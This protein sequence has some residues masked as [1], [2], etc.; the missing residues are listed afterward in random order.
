MIGSKNRSKGRRNTRT[1]TKSIPTTT[2]YVKNMVCPK[3]IRVVRE[4]LRQ[5]HLD[6]RNVQ[7]GEVT[8]S[9][10]LTEVQKKSVKMAF[11]ANGFMIIEDKRAK[12]IE[13][14]KIAVLKLVQ[15]DY[16]ASPIRVK[17]SEFIATELGLNYYYLTTLFSSVE[18]ITI[19]HYAILQ[20]IERAKELIKYDE[21]TLSEISHKLGYSSLQ[22]L[23][24]QFKA[25]TGMS[26]SSF[27][28]LGGSHRHHIHQHH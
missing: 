15:N 1:P 9:G 24:N 21:L 17:Y 20:R 16:E 14:I 10:M 28:S 3:C 13:G 4:E 8:V 23:S 25:V 19:E 6:A 18:N 12:V 22:H 26:P 7:L 2:I 11:E 27:K 5:L